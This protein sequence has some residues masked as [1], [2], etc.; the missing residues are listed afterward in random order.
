MALDAYASWLAQASVGHK[1]DGAF[2]PLILKVRAERNLS[3]ERNRSTR[4]LAQAPRLGHACVEPYRWA[5]FELLLFCELSSRFSR[6]KSDA[7]LPAARSIPF[8][9][10]AT[11]TI[12]F[13]SRVIRTES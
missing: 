8:W 2:F 7:I 11:P 12:L 6:E 13:P 10:S 3:A 1:P 9:I 5:R 4:Q